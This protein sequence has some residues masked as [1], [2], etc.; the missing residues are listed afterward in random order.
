M[1]PDGH[2][3]ASRTQRLLNGAQL[4]GPGLEESST[5]VANDT[6]TETPHFRE[7]DNTKPTLTSFSVYAPPVG[8]ILTV[9][10]VSRREHRRQ[11]GELGVRPGW[12]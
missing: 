5:L 6:A 3:V 4:S 12:K 10:A 8:P 11:V 1:T 2:V 9:R 7:H